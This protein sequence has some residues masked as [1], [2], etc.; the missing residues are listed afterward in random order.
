[1]DGGKEGVTV[2]LLLSW[3]SLAVRSLCGC[4]PSSG[5]QYPLDSCNTDFSIGPCSHREIMMCAVQLF[6]LLSSHTVHLCLHVIKI[7][8]AINSL[9][10]K[11]FQHPP[12]RPVPLPQ[13]MQTENENYHFYACAYNFKPVFLTSILPP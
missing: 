10:L 8:W 4:C 12:A 6:C 11:Q 3:Q 5:C 13:V 2:C 9:Y 1:M 7:S